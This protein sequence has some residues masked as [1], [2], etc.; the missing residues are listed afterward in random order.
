M[1]RYLGEFGQRKREGGGVLP[2]LVFFREG[3]ASGP[4]SEKHPFQL[5]PERRVPP[6]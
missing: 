5:I 1:R 6:K 2:V 4:I 3:R